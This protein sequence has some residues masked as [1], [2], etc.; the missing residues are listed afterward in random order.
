MDE[1]ARGQQGTDHIGYHFPRYGER[2]FECDI[3]GADYPM[4]MSVRHYKTN[5]L[6]CKWCDDEKTN[7]DYLAEM[8]TPREDRYTSEQPVSCQGDTAE[9]YWYIGLWYEAEWYGHDPCDVDNEV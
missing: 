5:K 6:V 9:D 8:E 4:R 3:C 2:W 1:R 7:S